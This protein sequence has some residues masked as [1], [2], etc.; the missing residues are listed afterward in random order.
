MTDKKIC[1]NIKYRKKI[2]CLKGVIETNKNKLMAV[3]AENGE[4]Q[5]VL[6]KVLGMSRVTLSRKISENHNAMFTQ[7]EI[8]AIIKHYNLSQAQIS[9]IF[10]AE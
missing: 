8:S 1:D 5:A 10:F 6:A 4:T 7:G 3:I 2:L 9:D